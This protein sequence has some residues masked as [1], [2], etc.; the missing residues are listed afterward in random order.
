MVR[1]LTPGQRRQATMKSLVWFNAT[2]ARQPQALVQGWA[3][4]ADVAP[5][6]NQHVAN[7]DDVS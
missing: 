5:A 6:L 4:D 3:N 1:C 7:L 2:D